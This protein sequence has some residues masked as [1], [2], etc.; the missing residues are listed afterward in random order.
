MEG[1]EGLAPNV[2]NNELQLIKGFFPDNAEINKDGERNYSVRA[3]LN[4]HPICEGGQKI[5]LNL[6]PNIT[7][8]ADDS[9]VGVSVNSFL[10]N[11]KEIKMDGIDLY[12][13]SENDEVLAG[14][15][16]C[17]LINAD[18]DEAYNS[19]DG[20]FVRMK[21]IKSGFNLA[22][23]FHELG[24]L[25]R[26]DGDLDP[27]IVEDTAV[28]V[29]NIVGLELDDSS[30]DS[31][32]IEDWRM[33]LYEER[34]ASLKALSLLDDKKELFPNDP[35]LLKIKK[36]YSFALSTYMRSLRVAN[37]HEAIDIANLD[38]DWHY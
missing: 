9:L 3:T 31:E 36:A 38:S 2:E 6:T 34:R 37:G 11:N 14:D 18:E 5:I 30:L 13:I 17:N 27:K 23:Y 7:R 19:L 15:N 24:H 12:L 4:D 28:S 1:G 26:E 33:S 8:D 21:S 22:L 35:D 25:I 32:D 20:S 10:V 16:D 29:R